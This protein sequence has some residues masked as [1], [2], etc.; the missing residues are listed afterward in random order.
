MSSDVTR[1]LVAAAN[2]A[3]ANEPDW[4]QEAVRV[5]LTTNS[6]YRQRPG[7]Q[8]LPQSVPGAMSS[9]QWVINYLVFEDIPE[10][11]FAAARTRLNAREAVGV[12]R[13]G[14]LLQPGNGRDVMR[15]AWEETVDQVAYLATA[16]REA[17][18]DVARR[19][20]FNRALDL[21][22]DVVAYMDGVPRT[23]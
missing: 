5:D 1:K 15:D 9:H 22:L 19:R 18:G 8:P 20:L 16:V 21:M 10:Q 12:E 4:T 13:Y 14:Q 7:D 11:L 23:T 17:P 6:S 2:A 3:L